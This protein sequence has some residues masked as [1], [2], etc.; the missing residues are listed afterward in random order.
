MAGSTR[1]KLVAMKETTKKT[2]PF[3]GTICLVI[4]FLLCFAT[5]SYASQM[6][7]VDMRRA[8]R[9]AMLGNFIGG[10]RRR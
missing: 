7:R 2:N 9:I 4:F 10:I 6:R 5:Q 3:P 1:L 8:V